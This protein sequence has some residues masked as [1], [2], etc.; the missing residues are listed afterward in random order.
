MH[1]RNIG[2]CRRAARADGPNGFISHHAAGSAKAIRQAFRHLFGHHFLGPA[3]K[4][5]ILG[6]AHADHRDQ[7]GGQG[8]LGLRADTVAGF[9]IRHA[10]FGMAQNHI[11]RPGILQ[12]G[13]RDI[14]GMGA[15]GGLMAILPAERH[16][17]GADRRQRGDQRGGGADQQLGLQPRRSSSNGA[18]QSHA[19]RG[20]PMHFPIAGDQRAHTG[21]HA[22]VPPGIGR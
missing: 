15:L 2:L 4:P 7:A 12:H 14:P 21:G 1:G 6:L 11:S 22:G 10:A 19:I 3:Q 20:Q 13:G 5:V 8:G 18:G 17:P 9:P 16:R